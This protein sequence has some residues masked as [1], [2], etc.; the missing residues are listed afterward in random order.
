[1]PGGLTPLEYAKSRFPTETMLH[2]IIANPPRD[3]EEELQPEQMRR[4]MY[5]S[6]DFADG[7]MFDYWLVITTF[8]F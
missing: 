7:M 1:M 3:E 5:D 2:E 8:T 6:S 4:Q